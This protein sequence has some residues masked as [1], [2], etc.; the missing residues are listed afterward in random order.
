MESVES[1]ASVSVI[2]A[3]TQDCANFT[4]GAAF[5]ENS[6]YGARHGVGVRR[7]LFECEAVAQSEDVFR[8]RLYE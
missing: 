5:G 6:S 7:S 1:A 3:C 2:D 8:N 4:L